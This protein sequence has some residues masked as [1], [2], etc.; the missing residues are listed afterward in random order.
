RVCARIVHDRAPLQVAHQLQHPAEAERDAVLED[1]HRLRAEDFRVP[2]GSLREIATR[3]R[4]V[5]YIASG[6]DRR[7][8][9]Q[10]RAWLELRICVSG[11]GAIHFMPRWLRAARTPPS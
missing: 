8:V 7:V 6:R 2:A 4:D 11:Y 5:G 3:H 10:F 9:Q 1:P